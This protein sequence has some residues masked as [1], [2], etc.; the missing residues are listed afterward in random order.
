MWFAAAWHLTTQKNG[1]SALG[2]KRVL[3]LG[4]YQTVWA[5]LHR[6]RTAMVRPSRERLNGDVEVDESSFG[7][8]K[9]GKRGRGAAGKVLVA[10]AVEQRSPKGYGRA[11]MQ[12]ISDATSITLREFLLSNVEPG[13]VV[14][15]D[16][17]GS[18]PAACGEDYKHKP[19]NV[20]ASGLCP[21][22]VPLP[23]VH[24]VASLVKR[25]LLGTHQGAVEVDHLQA[26]L[27]EF[28]FRFNRRHSL[29]RGLLFY[30]LMQLA[31]GA[32]PL[33]YR[34]LVVNPQPK[35]RRP[36]VPQGMRSRP[37]SLALP[38]ADRPW[39]HVASLE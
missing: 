24:R 22:H 30:R 10:I 28:C 32:P 17:L 9:P 15:S 27:N 34:H 7:G 5:M 1:I 20:R 19:F 25:W 4:S 35:R 14:I 33:T 16:S 3:G 23:G 8:V 12:V 13:A 31:V 11:R 29:S 18:Y 2:L 37:E 26:Y 6:Y 21:A 38:P 36:I 39:R